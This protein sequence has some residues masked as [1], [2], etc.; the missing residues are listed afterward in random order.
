[1]EA[2]IELVRKL[3]EHVCV[4]S[5]PGEQDQSLSCAAPVQ[6]LKLDARLDRDETDFMSRSIAPSDIVRPG[7]R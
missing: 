5:D 6:D 7:A 3:I 2:I 4:I 1:M